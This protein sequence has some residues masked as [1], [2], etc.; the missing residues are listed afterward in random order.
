MTF[1]FQKL[2]KIAQRLGALPQT[3]VCDT[4]EYNSL[5]NASPKLDLHFPTISFRPFLLPKSWLSDNGLQLQ[6]FHST[7]FLPHKKFLF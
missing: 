2:T 7:I 5:L 1:F 4:F 6:I 3:P